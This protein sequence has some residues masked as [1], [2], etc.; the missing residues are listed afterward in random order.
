[1]RHSKRIG[2]YSNAIFV[3]LNNI[4]QGGVDALKALETL[5]ERTPFLVTVF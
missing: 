4:Q 1:M 5:Y 3:L 2:Y